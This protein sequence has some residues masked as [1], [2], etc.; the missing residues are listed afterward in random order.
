[1]QMMKATI[2]FVMRLHTHP[3]LEAITEWCLPTAALVLKDHLGEWVWGYR[4]WAAL[5]YGNPQ[6]KHS[7]FQL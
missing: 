7:H 2:S 6:R 4:H 5:L 3:A 1:M